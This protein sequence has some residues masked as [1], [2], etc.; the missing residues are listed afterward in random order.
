MSL[1]PIPFLFGFG[2]WDAGS[3]DPAYTVTSW[4]GW[5]CRPGGLTGRLWTTLTGRLWDVPSP[6][7]AAFGFGFGVGRRVGGPSLQGDVVGRV[8]L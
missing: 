8:E 2:A 3:G 6:A 4:V 1:T 7:D 5:R